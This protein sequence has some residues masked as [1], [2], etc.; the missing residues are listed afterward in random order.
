A[1]VVE[2]PVVLR[3]R[4]R[5]AARVRVKELER[6]DL[7]LERRAGRR[8]S[9]RRGLRRRLRWRERWWRYARLRERRAL[10][11]LRAALRCPLPARRRE[12]RGS[13]HG[14]LRPTRH[15]ASYAGSRRAFPLF[16][17]ETQDERARFHRGCER[18][19]SAQIGR[20]DRR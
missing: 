10:R 5:V 16:R 13:E 7:D 15:A 6:D 3:A 18:P 1:Y 12:R 9:R 19:P 11:A 4:Q 14:P 20:V 2:R 8:G 17:R